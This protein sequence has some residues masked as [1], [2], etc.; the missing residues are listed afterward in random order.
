MLAVFF[1]SVMVALT[2]VIGSWF[3]AS[4]PVGLSI[5]ATIGALFSVGR[6]GFAR[7]IGGGVLGA[8]AAHLVVLWSFAIS[9]FADD[10]PR[11]NMLTYALVAPAGAACG[12][13]LASIGSRGSV[14]R[15]I[16]FGLLIGPPVGALWGILS[17]F[18]FKFPELYEVGYGRF[19]KRFT[20]PGFCTHLWIWAAAGLI[21]GGAIGIAFG[22]LNLT[23][24]TAEDN[25]VASVR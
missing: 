12:A 24:R 2:A 3:A 8:F 15:P 5:G 21:L 17:L 19:L 9:P 14:A 10:T 22:M 4:V 23:R 7:H 25:P 20:F 6:G 13:I 16:L 18:V 11:E 1:L